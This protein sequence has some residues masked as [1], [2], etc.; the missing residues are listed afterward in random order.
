[1]GKNEKNQGVKKL[2]QM[3][4]LRVKYKSLTETHVFKRQRTKAMLHKRVGQI[5]SMTL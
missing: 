1:M 2:Q 4:S 3:S 5:S